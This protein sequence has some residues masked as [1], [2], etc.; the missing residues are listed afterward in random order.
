MVNATAAVAA[1]DGN[2][3]VYNPSLGDPNSPEFIAITKNLC[4]SMATFISNAPGNYWVSKCSVSSLTAG[5]VMA[6]TNMVVSQLQ[7]SNNSATKA[8]DPSGTIASGMARTPPS[9]VAFLLDSSS[10]KATSEVITASSPVI[11]NLRV[12]SATANSFLLMWTVAS[13]PIS[14][15]V[16]NI[17]PGG[18]DVNV[19]AANTSVMFSSLLSCTTYS[20]KLTVKYGNQ[21]VKEYGPVNGST[22][23]VAPVGLNKPTIV[24]DNFQQVTIMIDDTSFNKSSC[25]KY[26][27]FATI[28]NKV[29]GELVD[30]LQSSVNVLVSTKVQSGTSYKLISTVTETVFNS[31]GPKRT[32]EFTLDGT[33]CE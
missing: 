12:T 19:P 31:V 18:A 13:G 28:Q 5:S 3:Q 17:N 2:N 26:K 6:L 30:S 32:D 33:V 23:A 4:S 24:P 22:R 14:S 29:T 1:Q 11:T 15:Y 8:F 7:N 16:A 25:G 10:L 20:V 9:Q 27:Y 21:Q